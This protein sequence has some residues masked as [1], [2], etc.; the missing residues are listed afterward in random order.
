MVSVFHNL[1][2]GGGVGVYSSIS[3]A[4]LAFKAAVHELYARSPHDDSPVVVF[5]EVNHRDLPDGFVTDVRAASR[6]LRRR[7]I[8]PCLRVTVVDSDLGVADREVVAAGIRGALS[9]FPVQIHWR[10]S[11]GRRA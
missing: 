10:T 2:W 5:L 4:S 8:Y 11:D 7:G 3:D 9:A 6:T 1:L